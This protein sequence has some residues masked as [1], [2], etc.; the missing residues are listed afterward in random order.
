MIDDMDFSFRIEERRKKA[1]VWREKIV[2]E[3]VRIPFANSVEYEV[4]QRF[5]KLSEMIGTIENVAQG[6]RQTAERLFLVQK[7]LEE[8]VRIM[9]SRDARRLYGLVQELNR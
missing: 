4:I 9:Q 7:K 3:V 6:Y 5:D 2:S 8:Y 1:L